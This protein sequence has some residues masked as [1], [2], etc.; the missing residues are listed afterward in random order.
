MDVVELIKRIREG[1]EK[2]ETQLYHLLKP[3]FKASL[4]RKFSA[5]QDDKI[6]DVYDDSFIV[7][8]AAIMNGLIR[9]ESKVQFFIIRTGEFKC[10]NDQR[11]KK[12]IGFVAETAIENIPEGEI[13]PNDLIKDQLDQIVNEEFEK[14]NQHDQQLLLGDADDLSHLEIYTRIF[15]DEKLDEIDSKVLE[16]KLAGQRMRLTR[17]KSMLKKILTNRFQELP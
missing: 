16:R 2:A 10:L 17:L 7:L 12:V 9:D 14:L 3:G 5:I 1:D 4:K 15:P 13:D 6:E 8:L 11:V